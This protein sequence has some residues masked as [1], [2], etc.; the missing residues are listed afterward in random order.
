MKG[1]INKRNDIPPSK[2]KDSDEKVSDEKDSDE[3]KEAIG[4]NPTNKKC[5]YYDKGYCKYQRKCR[6]FHALEIGKTFL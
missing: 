3:K 5:R 2:E 1:I 6:Y 4:S